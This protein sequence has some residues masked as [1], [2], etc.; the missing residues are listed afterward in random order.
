M[1]PVVLTISGTEK[2]GSWICAL[3]AVLSVTVVLPLTILALPFAIV[4]R[5]L[6][7]LVIIRFGQLNSSRI[8]HCAT[9]TELYVCARDVG[10]DDPKT[11][12]ILYD[13]PSVCNRQL[14]K[15]WGRT[16][17]VWQFARY[18]DLV[19]GMLP[20]YE[21]HRVSMT[22]D[23]DIHELLQRTG[24]HLAFTV[25]EERAG[26]E[27]LERLGI[28]PG[29]SFVCL[30]ARD[31]T[32]LNTVYPRGTWGYHR[33]RDSEIQN[34]MP[35]AEEMTRRGRFAIRMGAV[36]AEALKTTNPMIIDY[37]TGG[38]TDFLDIF[39]IAKCRF[40]ISSPGGLSAVA[41]IFRRPVAYVN[42]VPLEYVPGWSQHDLFIPKKLWLVT[43]RRFLTFREILESG[44]GR[45]FR[46]EEY[47]H[48]GVVVVENTGEDIAAL[49]I[50]MEERLNGTWKATDED[51]NLQRRFWSLF[52][53]SEL[54]RAFRLRVGAEFLRRNRELLD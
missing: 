31:G 29:A 49:A 9:N 23:R 26:Y 34:Y 52:R 54:N 51:E 37:A 6:R 43:E 4:V 11:F 27:A 3:R 39:L 25:K 47:E 10:M 1:A 14:K 46:A 12:D 28:N 5:A 30:H 48:L 42:F 15:M 20:G 38:R 41:M 35:A 50:E 18:V 36:V 53:P 2:E 13:A 16:L 19:S 8:G 24:V 40:F 7:P 32:Y 33:Y 17:R 21:V 44:K 45:L 22:S